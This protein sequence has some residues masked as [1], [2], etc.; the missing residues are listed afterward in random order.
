[1]QAELKLSAGIAPAVLK[2]M[3]AAANAVLEQD[4]DWH[5]ARKIFQL[6]LL[7]TEMER[8]GGVLNRAATRFRVGRTAL[9]GLMKRGIDS[10]PP[11][12]RRP[13]K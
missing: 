1:L 6:V 10:P 11:G 13:K 2:G 8:N 12:R 4:L 5:R 3:K 7:D 9:V